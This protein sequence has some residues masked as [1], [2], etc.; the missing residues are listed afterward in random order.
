MS[1]DQ[2]AAHDGEYTRKEEELAVLREELHDLRTITECGMQFGARETQFNAQRREA[3]QG[4]TH[5]RE[6]QFN[7]WRGET[8]HGGGVSLHYVP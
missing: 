4:E 6:T 8:H 3:Q 2:V 7:A 5:R 1:C